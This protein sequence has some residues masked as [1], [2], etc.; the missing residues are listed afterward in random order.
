MSRI[1][2][3]KPD[4][5]MDEKI[6]ALCPE[7]RLLFIGLWNIADDEGRTR[8]SPAFIKGQLMPYDVGTEVSAVAHWLGTIEHQG[9]TTS[10][11]VNG[12]AFILVRNFKKHQVI[13][14]P[15]AS[16]LPPPP[17][18]E[19]SVRVHGA[20]TDGSG[21]GSGS[22][23]KKEQKAAAAA[24]P[25]SLRVVKNEVSQETIQ[26]VYAEWLELAKAMNPSL[27]PPS[28]D[29]SAARLIARALRT[30]S[31]EELAE[32]MHGANISQWHMSNGYWQLKHVLKD[33]GTITSHRDRWSKHQTRAAL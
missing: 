28:I 27:A 21:S 8:G 32:A 20:L 6:G 4:F 29:P 14:R 3:I 5:W 33:V 19:G 12:E 1:R 9:L 7:A 10:Y 2:T 18:T 31:P 16:R 17:F 13:N 25:V 15:S 26:R 11:Q 22:G 30:H 24:P 23:S